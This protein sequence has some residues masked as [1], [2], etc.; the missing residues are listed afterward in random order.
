MREALRLAARARGRAAP[1][2]MVG[3]VVVRGGKR[4]ASGYHVRDGRQH[5]EA[6]A[7]ARA[8]T[9]AR[10]A[11]LYI[12]LEPCAHD[13][14]TPPCVD[15]VLA[16]EVRRVVIAMR[17]P[18][19]RTAGRS[20]A[21]L[22]RAGVAVELGVEEAAARVL[23]QGFISRVTRRRPFTHLKLAAT[24][25]GRIATASGESRWIT[26]PA[27]REYVHRLRNRVDA[28]GVG[29]NTARLDDPELTA[30]R[31][32]R[33]IHTP[34]RIVVDSRLRIPPGARLFDG[35]AIVLTA[36]P[37]PERKRRALER[38]GAELVVVPRIPK[39]RGERAGRKDTP[40]KLDLR[41]A[42]RKLA[43]RGINE[44]L[45]EGGGGLGAALLQQGL[46]DRSYWFVAPRLIGA[47]G[48]P[49]LGP[50]RLSRLADAPEPKSW[51]VQRI[52]NDL[53]MLGEW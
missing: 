32:D 36:G 31:G 28:I 10:G 17:D 46:V 40:G 30:R 8:G 48:R 20:L 47:D 41:K 50:L 38:V 6:I 4:L 43:D 39:G 21:R 2:P 45:I 29:S 1:N 11:T 34:R 22:R 18:D 13:G 23:N 37:V 25:D 52:G 51:K 14:R 19:P 53:L 33:V 5:A 35:G 12:T 7:L 27:A 26:G 24:L 15:A 44:I 9:H 16:S 49:A 42:W 3:C